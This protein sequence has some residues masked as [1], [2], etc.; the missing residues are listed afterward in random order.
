MEQ[1]LFSR[2]F[3]TADQAGRSV[4]CL[5][6]EQALEIARLYRCTLRHVYGK[7]LKN[8]II[9]Y[10]YIRNRTIMSVKEQLRILESAVAVVGA[11]ALGGLTMEILARTGIGKLILVDDDILEETNLNRQVLSAKDTLGRSKAETGASRVRAVNPAVD[12]A[13][14][15]EKLNEDNGK[16]LL[17]GAAVIVDALDTI[18]D[19][20]ALEKT[21]RALNVPLVHGA[22]AGFEGHVM[23]IFPEDRGLVLLYGETPLPGSENQNAEAVL[24]VPAATPA[25]IAA[26]QT[27]EVVKIILQRGNLFRNRMLHADLE[28]GR[29]SEFS[30]P[31]RARK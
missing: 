8:N 4:R 9:P 6:E 31:E 2:S 21:A 30:F 18:G 11:G 1:A 16:K 27:M 3:Q 5:K 28:T 29:F 7:A 15:Q 24:G 20:L 25:L 13:V 14:H 22:V 10:R 12:M 17:S 26:L 19:R 23:T